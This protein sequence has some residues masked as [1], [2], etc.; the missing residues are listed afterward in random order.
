MKNSNIR[1]KEKGL[2]FMDETCKTLNRIQ[3]KKVKMSV[4]HELRK[5]LCHDELLK[6]YF[7]LNPEKDETVVFRIENTPLENEQLIVTKHVSTSHSIVNNA[8]HEPLPPV[9]ASETIRND[10]QPDEIINTIHN[11][12]EMNLF[13][14]QLYCALIHQ[15]EGQNRNCFQ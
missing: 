7:V 8:H 4:K 1:K 6:N 5:Q 9:Q 2:K 10:P 11:Q 14:L 13:L 12:Q 3:K 15:Q